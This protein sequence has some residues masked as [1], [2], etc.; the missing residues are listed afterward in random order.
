MT[1]WLRRFVAVPVTL[2]AASWLLSAC[3][4]MTTSEAGALGTDSVEPSTI[5]VE[6]ASQYITITNNAGRPLED[7]RIAILPVGTAPPFTTTLRRMENAEKRDVSLAMFRGNDGT[8]FSPRVH[9][10]RQVTVSATDIV[11]KKH[12][13]TKPWR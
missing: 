11:G 6:T 8:T 9:R 13:L 1:V 10:A 2:I 7:I 12:E 3:S 4:N 5:A